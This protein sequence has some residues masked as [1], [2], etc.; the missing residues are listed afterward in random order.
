MRNEL[1]TFTDNLNRC[2]AIEVE[3]IIYN[4]IGRVEYDTSYYEEP[5]VL[6]LQTYMASKVLSRKP[7][8][9]M[10]FY[11]DI[12]HKKVVYSNEDKAILKILK[13]LRKKVSLQQTERRIDDDIDRPEDDSNDEVED[14]DMGDRDSSAEQ[15]LHEP[16]ED[17]NDVK[18]EEDQIADDQIADV[19][20]DIEEELDENE[21]KVDMANVNQNNYFDIVWKTDDPLQE[22]LSA[23][24]G[25]VRVYG[26]FME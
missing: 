19:D 4:S 14:D 6:E 13:T 24:K 22:L 17:D 9:D 8:K 10:K 5:L 18:H 15:D 20:K 7:P 25:K 23:L 16:L 11:W 2:K 1:K 12:H 21:D 3:E 26:E